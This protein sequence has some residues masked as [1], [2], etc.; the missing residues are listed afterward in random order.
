MHQKCILRL[1]ST[2]KPLSASWGAPPDPQGAL[3]TTS[4]LETL[5]TSHDVRPILIWLAIVAFELEM[6]DDWLLF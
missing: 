6:T 4:F 2:I 1:V 5:P 3:S